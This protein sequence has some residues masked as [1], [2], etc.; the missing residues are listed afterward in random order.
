MMLSSMEQ[1]SGEMKTL[2]GKMLSFPVS[3]SACPVEP[4]QDHSG[5]PT[6]SRNN[7]QKELAFTSKK[8]PGTAVL[9]LSAVSWAGKR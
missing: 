1:W 6:T 5:L 8:V 7:A 3:L 4:E 9:L 2:P